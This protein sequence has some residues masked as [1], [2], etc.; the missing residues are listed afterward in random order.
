MHQLFVVVATC[1]CR[2]RCERVWRGKA[3]AQHPGSSHAWRMFPAGRG[4][5]GR[6]WAGRGTVTGST[7]SRPDEWEAACF[8]PNFSLIIVIAAAGVVGGGA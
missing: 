2:T 8:T 1:Y 4:A 7:L 5:E 3:G 6:G